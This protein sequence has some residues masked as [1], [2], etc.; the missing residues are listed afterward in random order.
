[1]R[2]WLPKAIKRRRLG[3]L[4]RQ[5]GPPLTNLD[6]RDNLGALPP[7]ALVRIISNKR[8]GTT[9]CAPHPFARMARFPMALLL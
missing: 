1:M 3:E 6:P 9:K 8:K 7:D 4:V 2:F 5:P